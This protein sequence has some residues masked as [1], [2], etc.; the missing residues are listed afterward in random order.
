MRVKLG[1]A[2]LQE[3]MMMRSEA[4]MIHFDRTLELFE[5]LCVKSTTLLQIFALW[6]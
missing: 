3:Q 4:E 6:L 1:R 5:V 2:F